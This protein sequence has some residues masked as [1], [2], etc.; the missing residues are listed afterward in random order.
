MSKFS[1]LAFV[2]LLVLSQSAS[3][4]YTCKPFSINAEATLRSTEADKLLKTSNVEKATKR[5]L[6]K[7]RLEKPPQFFS[8]LENKLENGELFQSFLEEVNDA[9]HDIIRKKGKLTDK[10]FT[11]ETFLAA[12]VSKARTISKRVFIDVTERNWTRLQQSIFNDV[13]MENW[14]QARELV[15][16][17]L[18]SNLVLNQKAASDNSHFRFVFG[19]YGF[20]EVNKNNLGK[21]TWCLA[22]DTRLD[23]NRLIEGAE[24]IRVEGDEAVPAESEQPEED[25]SF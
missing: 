23:N 9:A 3:A 8:M 16:Q 22:V 17:K 14:K 13:A 4:F 18:Q 10:N 1:Q 11:V 25:E 24:K 6:I 21:G 19:S 12:P 2:T 20:V 15:A 5:A 7:K